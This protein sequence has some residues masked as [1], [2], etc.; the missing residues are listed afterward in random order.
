MR[1]EFHNYLPMSESTIE[2]MWSTCLFVFDTNAILDLYRLSDTARQ[3]YL[4][5]LKVLEARTWIPHQVGLEFM[6][7][8]HDV[9]SS[10]VL[11]FGKARDFIE[12]L[13]KEIDSS[14]NS[15]L[16]FR[17]H[18]S[19]DKRQIDLLLKEPLNALESQVDAFEKSHP[20]FSSDDFILEDVLRLFE[21]KVGLPYSTEEIERIKKEGQ[22][23]YANEVPPGYRDKKFGDLI[24]WFQTIEKAKTDGIKA[25]ILITSDSKDDWWLKNHGKTIGPHPELKQEMRQKASADFHM[26]TLER[27][28]VYAQ[29]HILR[30]ISNETI[31]EVRDLE[32][33]HK[34]SD[35]RL[36]AI[37]KLTKL[38]MGRPQT[39]PNSDTTDSFSE[40]YRSLKDKIATIM[41]QIETCESAFEESK[42]LS[43]AS[44][45][46]L[47]IRYQKE[48]LEETMNALTKLVQD[49]GKPDS[50]EG[51]TG[52]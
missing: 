21:G 11:L 38:L 8:R 30:E 22:S 3:Q 13:R 19:L 39:R 20:D 29:A 25:L 49:L 15:F 18:P 1:N 28:M 35:R 26:Y 5:L 41:E 46:R 43:E 51:P 52:L 23:R 17:I 2:E 14:I 36:V 24:L 37:D 31:E 6:R 47:V 12:K 50:T 48:Q 27:F 40:Q 32:D 44:T 10:Q 45:W 34:R 4:N 7:N 9:I 16:S 33:S 42:N